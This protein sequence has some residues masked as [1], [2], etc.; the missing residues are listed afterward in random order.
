MKMVRLSALLTGRLY[1]QEIF[2]VLI[3]VE[4]GYLSRYSD[5]LLAERSGDRIPVGD[6]IF[7]TL[8]Y[9]PW[10]P[11]SLLYNGYRIFP[12]GKVAGAWR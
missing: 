4:L 8:P 2:L 5:S 12:G 9:R 7:R 1:I 11:P 3:S 10:D 6:E